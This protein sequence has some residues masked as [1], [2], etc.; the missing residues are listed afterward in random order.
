M[1]ITYLTWGETPRSYG[2]FGSQVIG[3][4][5]ATRNFSSEVNI[6]LVSGVP[7]IHSGFVREKWEYFK[8]ISNI[9]NILGEIPFTRLSIW[10]SQN[11]IYPSRKT[12]I[13]FHNALTYLSL[14]RHLSRRRPDI[15]H[16][17]GYHAAYAAVNLRKRFQ[18]SYKII[19]DARGLWP[20]E[21]LLKKDAPPTSKDHFFFKKL[22]KKLLSDVDAVVAVSDT[23]AEYFSS[24]APRDSLITTVYLSASKGL[25]T[26]LAQDFGGESKVTTLG[27]VGA[28]SLDT[29]HSPSDLLSLYKKFRSEVDKP[30]L[31][32]VTTS[33]HEAIRS[34]FKGIP[35]SEVDIVS[36]Y[37]T[38]EV[39]KYLTQ[40]DFGALPYL[41]PKNKNQEVLA[42]TVLAVKTAEYLMNGIPVLCN[43]FC[44]GAAYLISKDQLGIAYDP[45]TLR[46]IAR[47]NLGLY[48]RRT[49][50]NRIRN[51]AYKLMSYDSNAARLHDLYRHVC[52]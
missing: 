31:L 3:Q 35:T 10:A 18:L 1:R 28:L 42:K 8:Q 36:A 17:R 33:N 32:I 46:E 11:F 48:N 50:S 49:S 12:L 34:Y 45:H 27:Y 44:G 51:C 38:E 5:K 14:L 40:M 30:R 2:V 41:V 6:E 21:M 19:F 24:I 43:K 26:I 37:S 13:L 9:E 4:V 47:E 52:L 23:M 20:E 39:S 25:N 16:C 29:W 15:V 22:E 7:I